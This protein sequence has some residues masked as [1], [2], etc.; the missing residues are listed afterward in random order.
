MG[1]ILALPERFVKDKTLD[2]GGLTRVMTFVTVL[3][4]TGGTFA[5]GSFLV[6]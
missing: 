1:E 2:L 5:D 6:K 3:D 4:L